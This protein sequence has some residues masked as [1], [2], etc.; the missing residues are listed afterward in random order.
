MEKYKPCYR[1]G[2]PIVFRY[3]FIR[4]RLLSSSYIIESTAFL[5]ISH[6]ERLEFLGRRRSFN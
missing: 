6:N 3:Q 4:Y 1:N 2:F 5:K